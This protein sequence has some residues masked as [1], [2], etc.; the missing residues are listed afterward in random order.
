MLQVC[1]LSS[2]LAIASHS[3]IMLLHA[4]PACCSFFA[5]NCNMPGSSLP[6]QTGD[7]LRCSGGGEPAGCVELHPGRHQRRC[8]LWRRLAGPESGQHEWGWSPEACYMFHS[9]PVHAACQG[10]QK[11]R[12]YWRAHRAGTL[13]KGFQ[14]GH[15]ST[16]TLQA[17][18]CQMLGSFG[19][20]VSAKG[21]CLEEHCSE[22]LLTLML[23]TC[24]GRDSAD[25]ASSA[26]ASIEGC[27]THCIPHPAQRLCH[28]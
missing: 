14:R 2:H 13:F 20:L 10:A 26:C 28:A 4:N 21:P 9:C 16:Y 22:S 1:C 15:S 11:R 27:V 25:D 8:D 23:Y 17:V 7:R 12:R 5:I 19:T 3:C 6:A 24:D 18:L